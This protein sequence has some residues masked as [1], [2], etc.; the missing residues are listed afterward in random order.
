MVGLGK[1]KRMRRGWGWLPRPIDPWI[2][3]WVVMSLIA[4]L[5]LAMLECGWRGVKV[6]LLKDVRKLKR[7]RMENNLEKSDENDA[8]LL[9]RIPRERFRLLTADELELKIRMRPLKEI[10]KY[11]RIVYWRKRL[12]RLIKDGFDYNFNESLRLMEAGRK[13]LSQ[14]IVGQVASPPFMERFTGELVKFSE[15]KRVLRWLYWR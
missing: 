7:L 1:R 6:Y 2:L 12:K 15:L 3:W 8:M 14:E 11:E 4:P 13:K 10:R 9:V 5:L